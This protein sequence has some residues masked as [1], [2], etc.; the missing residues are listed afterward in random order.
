MAQTQAMKTRLAEFLSRNS[1]NTRSRMQQFKPEYKRAFPTPM[2]MFG[3]VQTSVGIDGLNKLVT[4]V[5]TKMAK[6]KYIRYLLTRKTPPSPQNTT[7]Q[8]NPSAK[9]VASVPDKDFNPAVMTIKTAK[10]MV[11]KRYRVL[12]VGRFRA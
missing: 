2:I 3:R 11:V 4:Q 10:Y 6:T 1:K 5:K 7:R 8:Q 12:L 9:T